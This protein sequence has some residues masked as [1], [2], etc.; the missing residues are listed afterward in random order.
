MKPFPLC[1]SR[2][3]LPFA[4]GRPWM[5]TTTLMGT[6][7]GPFWGTLTLPVH[8]ADF[9][10]IQKRGTLMSATE[11]AFAPFNYYK[12]KSLTGFE[13]EIVDSLA[14]VLK[15][16]TSWKTF[17]FDSLLI[18]LNQD[19]YDLV[20]A[21]HA[22]TEERAKAVDFAE[23]H[24]CTGGMILTKEGGPLTGKELAGKTVA[25]Q[26]GT[27]YLTHLKK[28]PGLKEVKTYPK[29]PDSFQALLSGRVDAVVTDKFL[30]LEQAKTRS[31]DH[32]KTGELLFSER[33][34]IAVAKGNSTL[35]TQLNTALKTILG[36]GTYRKI[37]EKYFG[38]DIRCTH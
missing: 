30:A 12:G 28:L 23:P 35:K 13:V 20:A 5:L 11:G 1:R 26:V 36:N 32:L 17:P 8:A 2:F 37:S 34:S 19:R 22:D 14:E 18:G 31:A 33:V 4:A 7:L 27:S 21:S 25:V 9:A 38:H 10:T 29:D 3:R 6:L 15:L 24:Y 16:K